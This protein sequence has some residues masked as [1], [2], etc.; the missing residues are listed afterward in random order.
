[1]CFSM[2]ILQVVFVSLFLC[3]DLLSSAADVRPGIIKGVVK[4]NDGKPAAYVSVVLKGTTKGTI[5]EENGSFQIRNVQPGTYTVEV[6]L[7]GYQ[8]VSQTVTVTDD[9]VSNLT[10]SLDI[11]EQQLQEVIIKTRRSGYK[12]NMPSAT[13]RLN[14]PLNEVPQNIQ[15]ITD[16]VLADQQITSLSD[17]ITR[18]VSGLTKLEHWG[19]MYARVNMRGNRAAAFRNGMNITSTWGP[20]T[21]DMSFVDHIEFV[22]GPAGFMMS[23]GDPSGIYNVVT[24]R[25][26]GETK[27]EASILLGSYDFYRS[28]VDLDGKLSKDGKVLYRFNLMGQT[29]NS[30]RPY[31]YNDRY[32]IAPVITYK[33][34][35]QTSVTA[36]YIFQHAKMSN[37]GSYYVFSAK[38]F[39][40]LPRN[41][42]LAEKGME[43]TV[44]DDHNV[45]VNV[46][47]SFNSN[48]KITAQASYF[49]YRQT[50]SSLWLSPIDTLGNSIDASGNMIRNV[51]IWDASNEMKFGQVFVNGTMQTG[52][53]RHRI[54]AGL[55]LG[56]KKYLADW[57]QSLDIDTLGSFNIYNPVHGTPV[58]GFPQFDRSKSLRER[59][60][61]GIYS[62]KYTG[63]YLQDELGFLNNKVRL[64]LAARYTAAKLVS[65]GTPSSAN[66]FTPRIGLSVDID[67]QTT[68][69]AL[70]DQSF[71][72]QSGVRRDGKGILPVTGNN[73]EA[74][75]KRDWFGGKWNTS[76]SVYRI[77]QNNQLLN[78]PTNT[79]NEFYVVQLGQTQTQGIE[80]DI[81]GQL[82]PG[83]NLIANYALNDSKITKADTSKASQATLGNKLPGYAKHTAN[84][85]LTYRV[86]SGALAHFGISAGF[87]YLVDRT[88]WSWGPA[89]QQQAMPDYFKLES[90]LSYEKD[91][92]TITA[93]VFNVLNKY[94]F[95]GDYYGYGGYYDYQIEAGRNY[96]LGVAYRF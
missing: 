19:D 42:T 86:Q 35:D 65:Y 22:K 96:R 17:G 48:W 81:R 79:P 11:S 41:T 47:H 8:D 4:L 2:R 15:I 54:L 68:A 7:T 3:A 80:L 73:I 92:I 27:G 55:D 91:R 69:Y 30:F 61:N 72:P 20:L 51:S 77:L 45:T 57:N 16:K 87:T 88:T 43:P 5:T 84:G 34:D 36:E 50:G 53:I 39:E 14:E 60:G 13:L 67:K 94:L 33:I 24:K 89:S 78:D 40:K 52:A 12:S 37:V 10:F 66:R 6:S 93:N 26:T 71:L 74:G 38:G 31:E 59:A 58:N 90:G 82:L 62:E 28:T 1:M 25:P 23:N 9:V 44:I 95:A 63:L 18:N 29:K 49:S 83:L 46:Q 32:S 75:I 76:L 56:D 64:T 21:E 85:W 70:F